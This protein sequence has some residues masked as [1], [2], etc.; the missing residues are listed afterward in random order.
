MQPYCILYF[1][2]LYLADTIF[3][4]KKKTAF[5]IKILLLFLFIM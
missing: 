4:Q 2:K 3:L 1:E 5:N